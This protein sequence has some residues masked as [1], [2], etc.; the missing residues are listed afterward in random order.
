MTTEEYMSSRVD[1][2]LRYYENKAGQAKK[3]HYRMQ[4]L[5]I[6]LGVI[7][8]VVINLPQE[9][10]RTDVVYRV[11]ITS[12]SVLLGVLSGLA[13]FFNFGDNWLS[14]RATEEMLKQEKYLFLTKS[15]IYLK[16]ENAFEHFVSRIE[17]ILASERKEFRTIMEDTSQPVVDINLPG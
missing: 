9:L 6:M 7:V 15:G 16:N 12:L 14:F 8:P 1:D 17:T 4:V 11:V 3:K 13:G 5:I 10:F 2:Q